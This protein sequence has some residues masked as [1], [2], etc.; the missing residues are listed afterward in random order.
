MRYTSNRLR[1]VV[2]GQ[3]LSHDQEDREIGLEDLPA[4]EHFLGAAFGDHDRVATAECKMQ[5]IKLKNREFSQ[6]W[7]EFQVIAADLDWNLSALRNVF[8]MGQSVE[9]K[10]CLTYSDMPEEFPIVVTVWQ[11]RDNQIGQRQVGMGDRIWVEEQVL[12][13]PPDLR[14]LRNFCRSRSWNS[15]WVNGIC[16]YG[17]QRRETKDFGRREGK[18]VCGWEVFVLWRE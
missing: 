16:T 6:Y 17:S 4:D 8:R 5:E 10:D 18:M 13:L 3:I 2:L 7:A 11:K 14:P 15:G 1:G 12:P 9:I